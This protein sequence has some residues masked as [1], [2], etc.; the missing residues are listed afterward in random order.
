MIESFYV[1][2][3]FCGEPDMPHCLKSLQEQ[4]VEFTHKV[5]SFKDELTA[6]NEVY[7]AFNDAPP[8]TIKLKLDADVV[9]YPGALKYVSKILD[10]KDNWWFT[11][12]VHDFF[13]WGPLQAGITFFCDKAKFRVQTNALKCDRGVTIG[14]G[15]VTNQRPIAKHAHFCNERTAFHYGF[16][17][18]LKGQTAVMEK[19]RSAQEISPDPRREFAI[20]GFQAASKFDWS[21]EEAY[22][23]HGQFPSFHSYG[24]LVFEE[25]F[26]D[27]L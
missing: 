18:G 23:K 11:P 16:H 14:C 9:L 8:G 25:L 27:A 6:H 2:T 12:N 1:C 26:R 24:D 21:N 5:I 20:K 13:T 7:Q 3:M 15:H 17:R 4:G 19:V 10:G 22:T